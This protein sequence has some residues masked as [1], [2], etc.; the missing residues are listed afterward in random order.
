MPERLT[1]TM[2]RGLSYGGKPSVVRDA[3]VTG[4]LV[5]V[6]KT[7]KPAAHHGRGPR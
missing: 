2:V 1:E 6:N 7:G 5:A 4:L 3:K